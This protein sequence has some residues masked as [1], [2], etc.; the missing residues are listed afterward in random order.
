MPRCLTLQLLQYAQLLYIH[1]HLAVSIRVKIVTY[2]GL[3]I[4]L[5]SATKLNIEKFN[6]QN[7]L[8]YPDYFLYFIRNE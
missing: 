5:I 3:N 8:L 2:S 1:F 6:L 4:G 7:K